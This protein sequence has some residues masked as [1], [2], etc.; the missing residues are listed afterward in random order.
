MCNKGL[1][2]VALL[3]L[4]GACEAAK[5]VVRYTD[6]SLPVTEKGLD[7]KRTYK[8]CFDV[9]SFGTLCGIIYAYPENLTVGGRVTWNEVTVFDYHITKDKVCAT[10]K[11]LIKLV[12]LIPQLA[13]FKKVIDEVLKLYGKLPA[14]VMSLCL[15][16]HDVAWS[17]KTLKACAAI[18]MN[19][20]C[21]KGK[22]QW[23]G[24]HEL[25]CFTI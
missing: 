6:V 3:A 13:P 7:A 15:R 17:G 9:G 8:Q 14:E 19:L 10:E 5:P 23:Q 21:W 4:L 16:L 11:Q 18:D 12:E 22:C 24:T 20:I 25:G 1:V 2:V